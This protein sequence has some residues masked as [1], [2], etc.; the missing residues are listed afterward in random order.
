[1][2]LRGSC[3]AETDESTECGREKKARETKTTTERI[4]KLIFFFFLSH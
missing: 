2:S 4:K 1:M 3:E